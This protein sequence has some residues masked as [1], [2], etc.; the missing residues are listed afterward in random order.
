MKK[1]NYDV[2]WK[3]IVAAYLLFWVVILVFKGLASIV[4]QAPPAVMNIITILGSWT[5]TIV[6][7][8]MLKKLS[9]RST[10]RGFY[11]NAFQNRLNVP[12]VLIIP[13]SIFGVMVLS[14]W[15]TTMFGDTPFSS[16]ISIPSA[17]IGVL[18]LTVFQGPSGEESGWRG[19]LRPELERR[20]KCPN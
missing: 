10:I 18:L 1:Q 16:L 11:K 2:V 5:P 3:Y 8:V 13:T 19:Y 7:L 9:P 15:L 17:I 4:L 14:A 6:L 12:L 20:C